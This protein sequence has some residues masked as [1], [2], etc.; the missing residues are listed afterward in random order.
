[1]TQTRKDLRIIRKAKRIE[2]W[3]KDEFYIYELRTEKGVDATFIWKDSE[4]IYGPNINHTSEEGQKVYNAIQK[5]IDKK[6]L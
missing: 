2:F 4:R 6:N 5:K 1:M 3:Y